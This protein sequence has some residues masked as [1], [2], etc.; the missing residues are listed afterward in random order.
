MQ[1]RVAANV[2][3]AQRVIAHGESRILSRVRLFLRIVFLVD[4]TVCES[5]KIEETN[6][7]EGELEMAEF[8]STDN[9]LMNCALK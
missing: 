4:I 8:G 5:F 7:R 1:R 3:R 2:G 6:S 9:S